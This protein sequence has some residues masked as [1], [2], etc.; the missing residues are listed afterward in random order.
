MIDKKKPGR[1]ATGGR[2]RN[3][4][5]PAL[6]TEDEVDEIRNGAKNE[7]KTQADFVMGKVRGVG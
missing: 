1:P 4:N 3:K 5:L 2:K 7:D 6:F